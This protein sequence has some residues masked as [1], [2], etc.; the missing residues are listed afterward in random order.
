ML[1]SVLASFFTLYPGTGWFRVDVSLPGVSSL[2]LRVCV[3]DEH[4]GLY[5]K[6]RAITNAFRLDDL[7][8]SRGHFTGSHKS[9]LFVTIYGH[10]PW[11]RVTMNLC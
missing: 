6:S 9:V 5:P 4:T 3:P 10:S 1:N 7:N 8:Y 11:P 2:V